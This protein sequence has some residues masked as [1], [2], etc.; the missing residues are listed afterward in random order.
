MA[1]YR[2][3]GPVR[4]SAFRLCREGLSILSVCFCDC[5]Y[6]LIGKWLQRSK[7]EALYAREIEWPGWQPLGVGSLAICSRR[8]WVVPVTR[9]PYHLL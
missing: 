5:V 7:F 2:L 3:C 9:I 8:F 6:D 1:D 4:G